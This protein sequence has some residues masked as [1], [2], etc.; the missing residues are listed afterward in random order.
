[1]N[2]CNQ[3]MPTGWKLFQPVF[4]IERGESVMTQTT[5]ALLA[6]LEAAYT[7][8]K[9][10]PAD[11][12]GSVSSEADGYDVARATLRDLGLETSGYKVSLTSQETQEMFGATSPLYG[13]TLAR[14]T[15]QAPVLL[16]LK[17]FNEPLIEVELLF[18]AL[19]DLDPTFTDRELL[20]A[21]TVSG[22]AEL[23]DSRFTNWFPKLSHFLVVADNA[24]SGAVV[25]GESTPGTEFS[26]AELANVRADLKANGDVERTGTSSAVLDNPLN[27]L[28]WLVDKLAANGDT[29]KAGEVVSAGTFFTPPFLHAGNYQVSFDHPLVKD[30]S[31]EVTD[32]REHKTRLYVF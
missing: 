11:W 14:T 12:E 30:L 3:F 13:R 1:V 32:Y 25:V 24:V 20:D 17:D 26:V 5:T 8:K 4:C 6:A 18:T 29:V 28:R 27:S 21:V 10:N 16:S 7:A 2:A 15:F 23:P 19:K 31:F 9:L 22:V